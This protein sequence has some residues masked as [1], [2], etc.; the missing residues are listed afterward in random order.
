MSVIDADFFGI[1]GTVDATKMLDS[2]QM[3]N[4]GVEARLYNNIFVRTGYKFNF[5]GVMDEFGPRESYQIS[6]QVTREHWYDQKTYARTDEGMSVG[7]GIVI[8]YGDYNLVVDYAW[9]GFEL[10]ENVNRFSL[11]FKF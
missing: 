8:P 7:A 1:K 9:T 2:D 3:I 4:A 5:Q 10:M 11:T 6:E